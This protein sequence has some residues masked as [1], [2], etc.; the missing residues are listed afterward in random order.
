MLLKI[1]F[2]E[3]TLEERVDSDNSAKAQR[4]SPR[5]KIEKQL[6]VVSF[7]E[8]ECPETLTR[9]DFRPGVSTNSGSDHALFIPPASLRRTVFPVRFTFGKPLCLNRGHEGDG[10]SGHALVRPLASLRHSIFPVQFTFGKP[11][12]L[13]RGHEGDGV[14]AYPTFNLSRKCYAQRPWVDQ[15]DFML[16]EALEIEQPCIMSSTTRRL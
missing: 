3:P 9:L 7:N 5:P 14:T 16:R 11:L 10:G 2:E 6:S 13:N 4:V 12:C 15:D 8:D 1:V